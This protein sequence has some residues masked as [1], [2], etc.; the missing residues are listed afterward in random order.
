MYYISPP[1]KSNQQHKRGKS[2]LW[3]LKKSSL[4]NP[5]RMRCLYLPANTSEGITGQGYVETLHLVQHCHDPDRGPANIL[6]RG[7]LKQQGHATPPPT[8][9]DLQRHITDACAN[10]TSAMLH[11]VQ[12]E[13]QARVQMYIVADGEKFDH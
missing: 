3:P 1:P 9:Q 8:L 11:R 13:V 6:G 7:Y 4:E 2:K 10:V 5:K 12:R